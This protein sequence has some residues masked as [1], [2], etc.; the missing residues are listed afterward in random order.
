MRRR[1]YSYRTVHATVAGLL[2]LLALLA[3][4]PAPLVLAQVPATPRIRITSIDTTYFP[5][6][7][8]SVSGANLP[9][10]LL[11]LPLTLTEDNTA[12]TPYADDMANVGIQ[13]ALILD[14]AGD[15]SK[16]GVTGEPQYVEVG[17]AARQFVK[18]GL[19]SATQDWL[20]TVSFGQ[21]K[22]IAALT[23]WTQ[24]HQAAVDSL[25]IYQPVPDIGFTPLY[26]LLNYG[27]KLFE[28][29]ALP[30]GQERV[31]V[32]FSDG[33]DVIS[34]TALSDAVSQAA[35]RNIR[36]YTVLIGPEVEA[37]RKKLSS[38]SE[39]TDGKYYHLA[40]IEGLDVLW[41]DLA[42]L[43]QQRQL[44]YRTERSRPGAL[45]S[46]VTL[47]DGKQLAH[48]ATAPSV[49]LQP[50]QIVIETPAEGMVISKFAEAFDTPI[51]RVPPFE[52]E[53]KVRFTW[54][55]GYPRGLRRVE[56][57]LGGITEVRTSD[58]DQPLAFPI[59]T[60]G[61]GSYTLRVKA[62][63]EVGLPAE[64]LPV[65]LII[66]EN[67]P[68]APTPTPDPTLV[69]QATEAIAIAA[70]ST[71]DAVIVATRA[72]ASANEIQQAGE[73]I[74]E[75]EGTVRTLTWA[76]IGTTIFGLAAL[77]YAFYILSN[78][79]R[80]RQATQ[81]ITGTVAAM[82]EPFRPRK[83][84]R[85][86]NEPRAQLTLVDDAGTPNLPKTIALSRI[87]VRLG[88]DPS[89]V[90]VPLGD[91]RISKLH[92][93]INEDVT[94]GSYKLIDEGSTSGTYLNDEEVDIQGVQLKPGDVIGIGPVQY[95]FVVIGAPPP[96][97]G[98]PTEV[99]RGDGDT[100]PFIKI[101]HST[102]GDR[103]ETHSERR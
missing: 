29:A 20:T 76:T 28:D 99:Y 86:N 71:A 47:P 49:P 79:D 92:C 51:D 6:I 42:A 93:R 19:L 68:P 67:R 40:S 45:K 32:I 43:Q 13:A 25:Y 87:G 4:I 12:V 74:A 26:D 103:T 22:Q 100:E 7:T 96:P 80:R 30:D 98:D 64:S 3:V 34:S 81:V 17:R 44:T 33:I 24:D 35:Q 14:A 65:G 46:V 48:T 75:T 16:A 97:T 18:L 53:I 63:D 95:R 70:T 88:R 31:I 90:D 23:G 72:A 41:Q 2:I 54:P 11:D 60:F 89:L 1:L 83:G 57:E 27:V 84:G 62:I 78:R 69:A 61:G 101:T 59:Q 52:Q 102:N 10:P 94:P 37:S 58:F 73:R 91:R 55:D 38:L 36:I 56:Y 77:G 15:V 21:D 39:L 5:E 82:T 9:Q 66:E 50:V 85:Q 8:V